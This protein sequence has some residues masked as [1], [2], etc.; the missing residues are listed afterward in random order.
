MCETTIALKGGKYLFKMFAW[1]SRQHSTIVSGQNFVSTI[2]ARLQRP[3]P[4][5]T[6]F[7]RS[8]SVNLS[9]ILLLLVNKCRGIWLASG[10]A[11]ADLSIMPHHHLSAPTRSRFGSLFALLVPLLFFS[12][13]QVKPLF[14]CF[15]ILNLQTDLYVFLSKNS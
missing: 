12:F 14:L 5:P 10:D 3:F 6:K 9:K 7:D 2:G 15:P 11:A 4:P 1:R 8:K 13:I